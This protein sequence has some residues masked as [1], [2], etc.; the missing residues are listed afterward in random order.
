MYAAKTTT[1]NGKEQKLKVLERH[2]VRTI[3]RA[4]ELRQLMNYEVEEIV[5][6]KKNCRKRIRY[7]ENV[8]GKII[9]IKK[10]YYWY[11]GYKRPKEEL[12]DIRGQLKA[13]LL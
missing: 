12:R 8:Q 11:L 10:T 4:N 6:R 5:Q 2:I 9:S 7:S 3:M 13:T 1:L